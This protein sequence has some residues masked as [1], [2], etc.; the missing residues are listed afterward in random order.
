MDRMIFF[1]E[2]SLRRAVREY[3]EHYH[4][5]RNH[6]GLGNRPIDAGDEIGRTSGEVCCKKRLGGLLQYYYRDAA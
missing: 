3:L 4:S 6:Q 1:G 2:C 5:E